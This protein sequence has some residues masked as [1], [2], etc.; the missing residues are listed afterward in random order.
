[1]KKYIPVITAS[2]LVS[3]MMSMPVSAKNISVTSF[4]A[5]ANDK[6]DDTY[7]IQRAIDSAPSGATVTIPKGT[8]YSQQIYLRRNITLKASAKTVMKKKFFAKHPE[9][10]FIV[11]HP[12]K[13]GYTGFSK[14]VIEGGIWDGQIHKDNATNYH[15]GIEIDHGHNLTIKNMTWKNFSGMHM[16]EVNAVKNAKIDHVN[17]S[18]HYFY[19][20][21]KRKQN[22]IG[23]LAIAFDSAIKGQG[24]TIPYDHT[25]CENITVTNC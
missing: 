7:A 15:K 5:K 16:I 2:L 9:N 14:V 17:I 23:G 20:G 4:G 18:H 22:L 25:T 24:T 6:K 19:K 21:T 10:A 3:A 8:F 1:M 13:K 11:F 12:L